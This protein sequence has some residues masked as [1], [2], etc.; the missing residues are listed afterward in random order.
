MGG[1]GENLT[2]DIKI[3]E[4]VF[5]TRGQVMAFAPFIPV[6]YEDDPADKA[7]F[8]QGVRQCFDVLADVSESLGAHVVVS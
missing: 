5:T 8:R 1:V 6:I 7:V 2:K 4:A 3:F